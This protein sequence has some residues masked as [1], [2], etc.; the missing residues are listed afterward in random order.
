MTDSTYDCDS[1]LTV[2]FKT[3]YRLGSW[4]KV[5]NI[6]CIMGGGGHV[7][8][9]PV[10]FEKVYASVRA[11]HGA[12]CPWNH[13]IPWNYTKTQ[14]A[15][16]ILDKPANVLEFQVLSLN[17]KK[18]SLK[19]KKNILFGSKTQFFCLQQADFQNFCLRQAD[20]QKFSPVAGWFSKFTIFSQL[21]QATIQK[22]SPAPGW[23]SKIFSCG[24]LIFNF[25]LRQ[26]DF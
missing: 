13:W 11:W 24:R 9:C 18:M 12:H 4:N 10:P 15:L 6:G 2:D 14:F 20:V 19:L 3:I 23:Y 22:F 5:T 8:I 1:W 26:A 21:W 7:P 25:C 16:E 17:L